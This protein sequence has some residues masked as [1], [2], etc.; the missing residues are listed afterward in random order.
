MTARV[1]LSGVLE[2]EHFSPK[3]LN[4]FNRE[5]IHGCLT[6]NLGPSKIELLKRGHVNGVFHVFFLIFYPIAGMN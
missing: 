4:T 6:L 5:R 2:I 3:I 1:S